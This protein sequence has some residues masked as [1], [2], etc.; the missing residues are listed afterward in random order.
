[1]TQQATG[2]P[3]CVFLVDLDHF[4]RINDTYGHSAGDAVLAAG[5]QL[6]RTK[7]FLLKR[8]S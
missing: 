2:S 1:M 3:G 6:K 5:Q 8:P 7:Q 4:K